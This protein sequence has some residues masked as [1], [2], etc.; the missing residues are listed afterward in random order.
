LIR[1]F[2][3]NYDTMT[4]SIVLKLKNLLSVSSYLTKVIAKLKE[5]S[6]HDNPRDAKSSWMMYRFVEDMSGLLYVDE[7]CEGIM[8]AFS[9]MT[10]DKDPPNTKQLLLWKENGNVEFLTNKAK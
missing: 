3:A 5:C 10:F 1:Y 4:N 9:S 8:S 7:Q 2:K 6:S